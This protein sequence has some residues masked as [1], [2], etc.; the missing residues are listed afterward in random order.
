MP[1]PDIQFVHLGRNATA[2]TIFITLGA[3]TYHRRR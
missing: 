3:G 2:T 1:R